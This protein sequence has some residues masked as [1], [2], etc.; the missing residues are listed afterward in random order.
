MAE[1]AIVLPVFV[2]ILFAV[3]EFGRAFNYWIDQTHL[4]NETA[5]WVV[6]NKDLSTLSISGCTAPPTTS[7]SLTSCLRT[8]AD[9]GE[10]KDTS[11][12]MTA[13]VT[14][15]NTTC[16]VGDPATVRVTYTKNWL[17]FLKLAPTTISGS[18]TMRIEAKPLNYSGCT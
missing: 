10:L 2:V 3:I 13:Q 7:S 1:M 15:P 5:R 6:V 9:S 12:G 11:T 16:N 14:F 8:Q 17:P 4:A 18:A